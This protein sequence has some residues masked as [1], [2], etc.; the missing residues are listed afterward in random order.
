MILPVPI[1]WSLFYRVLIHAAQQ[2]LV[3][4]LYLIVLVYLFRDSIL[5][6]YFTL[7]QVSYGTT[8]LS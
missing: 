3:C 6:I 2:Q 7:F 1:P 5:M 8:F 4:I